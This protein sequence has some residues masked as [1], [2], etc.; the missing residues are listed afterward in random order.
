[1]KTLRDM[2]L[3]ELADALFN[4]PPETPDDSI[5]HPT[6]SSQS[7]IFRDSFNNQPNFDLETDDDDDDDKDDPAEWWKRSGE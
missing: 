6:E 7:D 2:D 1:M 3:D 4:G 5:G